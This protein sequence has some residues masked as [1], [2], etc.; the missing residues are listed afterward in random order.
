VF[1]EIP[2]TRWTQVHAAK[3]SAEKQREL[4]GSIFRVYW[5]PLFFL[6]RKRGLSTDACE[7]AIQAFAEKVLCSSL[8]DQADETRGRM[9]SYLAKSFTH[10]LSTL[11]AHSMAQKRGAGAQH[12]DIDS[13]GLESQY[14]SVVDPVSAFEVSWAESTVAEARRLLREEH[15]AEKRAG[16]LDLL[17]A[18]LEGK[19]QPPLAELAARSNVSVPFLK[20]F[21]YRGK[22]RFREL[23]LEVVSE[24]LGPDETAEEELRHVLKSLSA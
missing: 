12:V 5:K 20:S 3:G 23:L 16:D 15:L 17:E 6:A 14:V 21:F 9:R 19:P 24:T 4:W 7:D 13:Q 1:A 2:T 10:H 11:H 22:Q 8:L 18:Y